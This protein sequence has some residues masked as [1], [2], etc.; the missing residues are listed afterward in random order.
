LGR[1]SLAEEVKE[2]AGGYLVKNMPGRRNNGTMA[3]RWKHDWE[4]SGVV[5]LVLMLQQGPA[6]PDY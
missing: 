5:W 4:L 6:T 2:R 1:E 3:L